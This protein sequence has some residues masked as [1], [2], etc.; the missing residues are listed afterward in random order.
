MYR[1]KYIKY[2][3]PKDLDIIN[4]SYFKKYLKYTNPKDLDIIN[5]DYYNLYLKYKNKYLKLKELLG[6]MEQKVLEE[7]EKQE[8]NYIDRLVEYYNLFYSL[9]RETD[10]NEFNIKYINDRYNNN[11]KSLI[12][13][14][15]KNNKKINKIKINDKMPEDIKQ[16][17]ENEKREL[18]EDIRNKEQEIIQTEMNINILNVSI[19]DEEREN[20]YSNLLEQLNNYQ[21]LKNMIEESKTTSNDG[22]DNDSDIIVFNNISQ[23]LIEEA[24]NLDKETIKEYKYV[25]KALSAI[26]RWQLNTNEIKLSYNQDGYVNVNDL[27]NSVNENDERIFNIDNLDLFI[28]LLIHFVN[29]S[30]KKRISMKYEDGNYYIRA[31]QGFSKETVSNIGDYQNKFYNQVSSNDY[32]YGFH[33][34]TYESIIPIYKFNGLAAMSRD[35]VHTAYTMDTNHGLRPDQE[36]IVI[37]DVKK[38][39]DQGI[40][41]WL[42]LNKVLLFERV[43][44]DCFALVLDKNWKILYSNEEYL[45][46]N[47]LEELINKIPDNLK[48]NQQ[49]TEEQKS[50]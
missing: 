8:I 23:E 5:K 12:A 43:P 2:T 41:P 49:E 40:Q 26:L 19:T 6:G 3:N 9:Q 25:D 47:L 10:E 39:E 31:N 50:D 24:N 34:T 7:L 38:V 17:K 46:I 13:D 28:R 20:N 29:K 14:I 4:I 44:L 1:N 37:V 15:K 32:P 18:E 35:M 16:K 33:G 21:I 11:I 36:I 42:S 27:M 22:T 45:N 30:D 48:E